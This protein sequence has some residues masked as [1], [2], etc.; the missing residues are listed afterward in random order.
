MKRGLFLLLGLVF[1]ALGV[2]GII[3][4]LMPTTIFLI[5]AAGCFARSSP[6][7]EAKILNHPTLGPSVADWREHGVIPPK[8]KVL[9]IGGILLGYVLFWVSAK[10]TLPVAIGVAIAMALCALYILTRPSH[11]KVKTDF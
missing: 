7:L 4:P 10:P 8:A 1:V 5:L 3:L 11:K 9:A 2:I 6:R